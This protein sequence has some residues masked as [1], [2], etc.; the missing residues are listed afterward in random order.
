MPDQE[1]TSCQLCHCPPR[2]LH[3]HPLDGGLTPSPCHPLSRKLSL[4]CTPPSR[5]KYKAGRERT[6]TLPGQHISV[7]FS[8]TPGSHPVHL[9]ELPPRPSSPSS[10]ASPRLWQC[11]FPAPGTNAWHQTEQRQRELSLSPRSAAGS[12]CT[13]PVWSACRPAHGLCW[14]CTGGEFSLTKWPNWGEIS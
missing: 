9:G 12:V 10:S 2:L 6:L 8:S 14:A 3:Q 7:T 4:T 5:V 1:A 13:E 11:L